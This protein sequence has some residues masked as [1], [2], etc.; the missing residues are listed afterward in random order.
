MKL[1]SLAFIGLVLEAFNIFRIASAPGIEGILAAFL[2]HCGGFLL[3]EKTGKRSSQD[4]GTR[5]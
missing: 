1:S 4:F 2:R 5:H 3:I